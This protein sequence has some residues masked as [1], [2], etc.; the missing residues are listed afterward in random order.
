MNPFTA[1]VFLFDFQLSPYFFSSGLAFG[2]FFTSLAVL[3]LYLAD[4]P[5]NYSSGTIGLC[6][7]PVGCT[8]LVMAIFGGVLSDISAAKFSQHVDGRMTM[9]LFA[10]WGLI[11]GTIGFGY[12]ANNGGA[13][14]GL[15]F[16]QSLLGM[17]NS[18]MLPSVS[19][20]LSSAR[21]HAAGAVNAL[22]MALCFA[23]SAIA[24]SFA[25]PIGSDNKIILQF[26]LT[27]VNSNINFKLFLSSSEPY[28]Y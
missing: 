23:I 17:G 25:I 13:L 2:C 9:V 4:A 28:R 22:M 1:L 14:A 19:S 18:V 3:P 11:A 5:Y 8:Q 12:T 26:L 7:L 20:Y 10:V 21:P 15:L 24:I 16:S 6:Y 27:Y